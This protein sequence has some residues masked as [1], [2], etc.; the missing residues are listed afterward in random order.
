[1]T[2]TRPRTDWPLVLIAAG[3]VLAGIGFFNAL[4]EGMQMWEVVALGLGALVALAGGAMA[5]MR[6]P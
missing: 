2:T 1:M 3:C 5:L 4:D 6:R